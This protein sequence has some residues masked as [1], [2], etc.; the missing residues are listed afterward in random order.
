[1][2]YHYNS[3][4]QVSEIYAQIKSVVIC[5]KFQQPPLDI[6]LV[7]KDNI[8]VTHVNKFDFG[9]RHITTTVWNKV[10]TKLK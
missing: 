5:F 6:F 1:V 10:A 8:F 4:E 2:K 7:V 3:F 9:W